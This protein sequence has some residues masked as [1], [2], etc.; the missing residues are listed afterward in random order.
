MDFA[1]NIPEP[2]LF[3]P[4]KHYLPFIRDFVNSRNLNLNDPNLKKLTREIKH[5]GTCVMDVYSGDLPLQS[6]FIQILD[7][8]RKNQLNTSEKYSKW[9][10]T[11]FNDFRIVSLSDNSQ[12]TLKYYDNKKRYVHIFPARSSPHSFRIKANTLKSAILYIIVIG[13]DYVSEEDLNAAR[14]LAGLSPVREVAD[15][16]AVTEMIEILRN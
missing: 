9:T 1:I 3:S 2:I 8:L 7:F 4:L 14:A 10:G 15:A 16:E 6:I 11:E 13:K 12:W 5:I